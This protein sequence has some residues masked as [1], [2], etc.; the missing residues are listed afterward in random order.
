MSIAERAA[1]RRRGLQLIDEASTRIDGIDRA[2][3]DARDGDDYDRVRDFI[4]DALEHMKQ[5]DYLAAES[6]ARKASLLAKQLT[7]R[8]SAPAP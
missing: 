2:K 5:E 4:R 1:Q 7:S 3:L 8:V 6:L